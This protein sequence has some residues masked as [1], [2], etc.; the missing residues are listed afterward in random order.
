M[1]STYEH[2]LKALSHWE[3]YYLLEIK[4]LCHLQP[5]EDVEVLKLIFL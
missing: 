4:T 3:I 5:E 1:L 2:L